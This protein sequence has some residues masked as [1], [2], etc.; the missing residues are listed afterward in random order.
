MEED[1]AT[2][3][4]EVLFFSSVGVVFDTQCFLDLFEQFLLS[5]R[6]HSIPLLVIESRMR[7]SI[8]WIVDRTIL[9][10]SLSFSPF[11]SHLSS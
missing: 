4:I 5:R 9:S 8:N 11:A 3:P 10:L 2:D 7:Y 6:H 1:K